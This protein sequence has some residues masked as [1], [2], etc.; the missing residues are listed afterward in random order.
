MLKMIK[1]AFSRRWLL[2]T[3]LVLAG[4]ALC[5]R[6]GIWQLD[7]LEERRAFNAHVQA[8]WAA[9]RLNL[10]EDSDQDLTT[11]EYRAVQ[12][13]GRYDYEHQVA[14]RNQYWQDQFGFHLLTPLLLEDGLAVLVDRGWIPGENGDQPANWDRFNQPVAVNLSG[15]IRLGQEEPDVGG[16]PD[17][18]RDE[19]IFWNNVNLKRLTHQLPYELLPVYIQLDVDES[20]TAPPIAYQ[21]ELELTEGSHAGYAG[22]WFIFASILLF[23]YPF[24]LKKQD[25]QK[26]KHE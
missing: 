9:P 6:L 26:G 7:R 15:I 21:P 17:Q 22:Q 20:N 3:F 10:N 1:S 18:D 5:I 24:Y 16:V 13:R 12:V 19:L 2:T 11:M 4:S 14:L 23:G 8:Q 25:P